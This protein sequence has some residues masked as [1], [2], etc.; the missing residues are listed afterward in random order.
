MS[1]KLSVGQVNTTLPRAARLAVAAVFFVG[2]AA[3]ANWVT[4]IPEIQQKLE[5]SNGALGVALLGTAVGALLSMPIT[6]W[7][8]TRVGSRSV[9]KLA[10]LTYCMA[11]P[12]LALAPNFLLLTIA[13]MLF[14]ALYGALDVAMNAQAIAVERR[15]RRP[16]MSSF[17]A[18]Y[19]VGGMAGAASGGVVASVGIAPVPHLLG[20]ALLLGIVAFIASRRLLTL[21]G[22]SI[23]SQEPVFV[24]PPRS[25]I[26]L[27][28]VAFC[29][30]LGEGAIADWSALYLRSSLEAEPGVAAGGFA[31]YSL[32]MAICRFIG[33]WL[34]QRLGSVKIVRFG[35]AIAATGLLLSLLIA[36]P[37]AALIGFACVG[38]GLSCI[39]PTVFSAAGRTS[40]IPPSVALAAVT[41]TGYFGFLIGPPLIGFVA[42][43]LTLR[44]A[45]SI[46]VITSAIIAVLAQTVHS[47]KRVK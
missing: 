5:L 27:G 9:T 2:G 23:K 31:V 37:M 6:G 28:V 22:V 44:V 35:G 4:R 1:T 13:L 41:T 11:L 25:L 16:I 45:L 40:G 12:L 42:D 18:W 20:A 43:F 3:F 46:V 7:L 32:A 26:G 17:H 39:V 36:Q 29:S 24:L 15:Y 14:G 47:S 34:T 30:M 21:A 38:V 8:V 10:A 33:D 19:S